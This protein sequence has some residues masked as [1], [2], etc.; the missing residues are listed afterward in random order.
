M[1]TPCST[2]TRYR[3]TV[4][5]LDGNRVT[6]YAVFA[7]GW[8]DPDNSSWGRPTDIQVMP[9]GALLVTDDRVG[10]IYRITYDR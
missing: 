6:D 5:T 2:A 7:A 10:A 8:L 9:D 3:I 4:A 1:C